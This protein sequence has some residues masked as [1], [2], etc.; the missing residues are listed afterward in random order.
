M[1]MLKKFFPFAFMVKTKDVTSLIVSIVIHVVASAVLGFVLGLLGRI[2]VV[3]LIAG[4]LGTVI[5]L[6][7]LVAIVLS[8]LVFLDVKI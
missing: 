2:P 1:D 3:G 7:C 5:G 4:V 8:V 6:Y